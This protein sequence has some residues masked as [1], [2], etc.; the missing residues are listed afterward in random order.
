MV[1]LGTAAL[2]YG[3]AERIAP[4]GLESDNRAGLT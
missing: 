4:F 3:R 1:S 2:W